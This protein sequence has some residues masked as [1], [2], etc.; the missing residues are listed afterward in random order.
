MRK[1]FL[2]IENGIKK[3]IRVEQLQ[4]IQI[5]AYEGEVTLIVGYRMQE[6]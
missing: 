4:D 6:L 3:G 2:R 1:E 5:A